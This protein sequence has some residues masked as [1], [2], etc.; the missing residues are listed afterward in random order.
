MGW[1]REVFEKQTK[2]TYT[3]IKL[4][5]ICVTHRESLNYQNHLFCGVIWLSIL[6]AISTKSGSSTTDSTPKII[7]R[8]LDGKAERVI[9]LLYS[10][11]KGFD[12]SAV[13]PISWL[14]MKFINDSYT[15]SLTDPPSR[16]HSPCARRTLLVNKQLKEVT[17]SSNKHAQNRVVTLEK[18]ALNLS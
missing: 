7:A 3:I 18:V 14:K 13:V 11:E 2:G 6:L 12:L 4:F 10:L 1:M 16:E 9:I 15:F 17:P 5:V 8:R